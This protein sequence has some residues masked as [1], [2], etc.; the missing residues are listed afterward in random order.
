MNNL[1][2]E[3]KKNNAEPVEELGFR[4]RLFRKAIRKSAR[5]LA[6]ELGVGLS[7]IR[8]IEK[9]GA[10]PK[11]TYLHYLYN[12]YGLNINWLLSQTGHMFV[13]KPGEK[14]DHL[15]KKYAEL[16]DLMQV[17]AVEQA[18]SAALTQIRNLLE[19]ERDDFPDSG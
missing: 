10:Y 5:D 13:E 3:I 17:P 18:I 11:I 19:L 12:K 9:G 14:A 16:L 4:F 1:D 2:N 15:F 7:V 6:S 8:Q